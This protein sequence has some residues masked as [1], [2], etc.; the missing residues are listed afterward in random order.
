MVPRWDP[1][2]VPG[3]HGEELGPVSSIASEEPLTDEQ[4]TLVAAAREFARSEL[5]ER[6]RAWDADESSMAEVLPQLAEMGF[7]SLVLPEELGRVGG[8]D[9][10]D[11]VAAVREIEEAYALLAQQKPEEAAARPADPSAG[12]SASRA[13]RAARRCAPASTP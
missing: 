12:R 3:N 4:A 6:D 13:G 11:R 1:V 5:L 2:R 9:P 8:A 7:L 10:K